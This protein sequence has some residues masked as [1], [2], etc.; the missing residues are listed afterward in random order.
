MSGYGILPPKKFDLNFELDQKNFL[1]NLYERLLDELCVELNSLHDIKWSKRTWRILIGPWLIRYLSSI[2]SLI[3]D[4]QNLEKNNQINFIDNLK[5]PKEL[6]LTCNDLI[7]FSNN[8]ESDT[9]AK[10][11]F[12][13]LN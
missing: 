8:I 5:D 1:D 10:K 6:V 9:F 7:E 2:N 12:I 3:I 13:R 11:F 4:F